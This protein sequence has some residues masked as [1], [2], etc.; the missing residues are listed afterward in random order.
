MKHAINTICLT[1]VLFLAG[2]TAFALLLACSPTGRQQQEKS[3]DQLFA[4]A[5]SALQH[6]A[7]YSDSIEIRYARGLQVSY[8]ADGVH[9]SITNPDPSVHHTPTEEF[10]ITQPASRFICTTALQLGNFEVLELEDKIVGMNSLRNLFSRQMQQQLANGQTVRIGKEGNFDLET[11]IATRPDFIFV[12]ASKHGGFEALRECGIPL[13]SHHGYKE[14]SPLG[15]AEWIKLIGLLTGE[16]RRANAVFAD[17]ERKYLTLR[18]EVAAMDSTQRRPTVI[19]GRQIRDGWYVAGGRS[20]LAQLFSDAGAD[21]IM[22]DNRDSGGTTLDFEAVYAR[23][24]H[25]DF[26]QTDGT[27]DGDFTLQ[28]LA[29]EDPRYATMDAYKAGRVLFC[30]FAQ[31]PYRELAGVQPHFLL[32][33]FVKA[34]HPSLL[35]NYTPHYYRLLQ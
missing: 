24:L 6:A 22:H 17:I 27:F 8:H 5:D 4:E 34:F 19:S 21:Y 32:A 26:W 13:I 31:T 20:Y 12:S 23:G 11:V 28:T 33:D 14:T 30:N 9:V 16:T 1:A 15:Q 29:D 25:A 7:E 2:S 3:A 10:V 18:S 35:P